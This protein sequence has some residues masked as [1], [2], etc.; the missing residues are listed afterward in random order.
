MESNE[1]FTASSKIP[2]TVHL[3][4]EYLIYTPSLLASSRLPGHSEV[5]AMHALV[6]LEQ[7]STATYRKRNYLFSTFHTVE[8]CDYTK[9]PFVSFTNQERLFQ[10]KNFLSGLCPFTTTG[11]FI[12][13]ERNIGSVFFLTCFLSILFFAHTS[14]SDCYK[15]LITLY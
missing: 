13:Q 1:W 4:L 15:T 8:P 3:I 5:Y 2:E 9:A 10:M 12:C 11:V 14:P 7:P 6:I